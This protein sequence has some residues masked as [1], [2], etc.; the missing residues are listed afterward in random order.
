MRAAVHRSVVQPKFPHEGTAWKVQPRLASLTSQ[1]KWTALGSAVQ[2][3][4]AVR[5]STRVKD[6]PA[7][8]ILQD[9]IPIWAKS[10]N[11]GTLDTDLVFDSQ[12]GHS[13]LARGRTKKKKS[14]YDGA[15]GNRHAE[16]DLIT[17]IYAQE[18]SLAGIT[19]IEIE[20]QPCP[21]CAVVLNALGLSQFV[22][23]MQSSKKDYPTWAPPD[24][25]DVS[26]E[27]ML[28]IETKGYS[29][30]NVEYLMAYFQANKF[31]T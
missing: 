30:K 20:K 14:G 6:V 2:R 24:L 18:K 26:W 22:K 13:C 28:G 25:G 23:Y 4:E 12:G 5:K 8:T 21:R 27:E 10:I 29:A 16:M 17:T 3:A 1:K 11:A 19:S 15:F 9:V 7:D 31:W